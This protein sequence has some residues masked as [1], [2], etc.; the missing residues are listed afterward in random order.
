MS[1][2]ISNLKKYI[3]MV[4]T[5]IVQS[6][7]FRSAY[8]ITLVSNTVYLIVIFFLWS[9]IYESSN[10]LTINGMSFQDTLIYLVLASSLANAVQTDFI[11]E[12]G[13]SIRTGKIALELVRPM[14]YQVY[15][16]WINAGRIILGLL[17]TF[18]PTFLLVDVMTKGYIVMG[19]NIIY[20]MISIS[21]A[22]II[23]YCFD[24]MAGIFCIYTESVWGVNI[25]KGI[26]V[27]ILSGATIPLVF[28]P[29]PFQTIMK[30]LPFQAI[31]NTPLQLLI[32]ANMSFGTVLK[33]L[34][35]QF[36]WMVVI[37]IISSQI[38]KK[39]VKNL[40]VNGG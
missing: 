4:K 8:F 37:I 22:V 31:Y 16:F 34:V 2:K 20:L 7:F 14:N 27:M 33:Y 38:W 29:E 40:T 36:L 25:V 35:F 39:I 32:N 1:K 5:G 19:M 30:C 21:M 11:W 18:F 24:F 3:C 17:S 28:F 13:E 12:F 26:V 9:A 10:T 6:L 15:I 23:N